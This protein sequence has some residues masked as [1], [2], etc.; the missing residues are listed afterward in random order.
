MDIPEHLN[1]CR[2]LHDFHTYLTEL[3]PQTGKLGGRYFI[4]NRCYYSMNEIVHDLAQCQQRFN[5]RDDDQKVLD[6]LDRIKKLNH[7][8]IF[9]RANFF[10]RFLLKIKSIVGHLFLDSIIRNSIV[11][12]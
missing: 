3:K 7:D 1:G 2:T 10:Q 5:Q 11:N 8:P 12:T 6:I 4:R 9:A